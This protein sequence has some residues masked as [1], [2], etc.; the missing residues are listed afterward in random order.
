MNDDDDDDV[1]VSPGSRRGRP[2]GGATEDASGKQLDNRHTGLVM[3][4][5]TDE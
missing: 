4:A 5:K 3:K 1:K 2:P